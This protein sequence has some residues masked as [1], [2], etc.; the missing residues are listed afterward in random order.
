[1][2]IKGLIRSDDLPNGR[3]FYEGFADR[4]SNTK[5]TSL[6]PGCAIDVVPIRVD[7]EKQ[8][9]D[10]SAVPTKMSSRR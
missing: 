10:F 3:W 9:V 5:G 6:Y 8:W 7:R 4:W 2:Q 1:L